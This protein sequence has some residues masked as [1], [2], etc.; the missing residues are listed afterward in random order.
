MQLLV[1]ETGIE[2]Q[3][4]KTKAIARGIQETNAR[5]FLLGALANGPVWAAV[6]QELGAP[7]AVS[8]K[9]NCGTPS[10]K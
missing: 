6:I 2:Q 1:P 8:T 10:S 9:N 5:T 7:R 4:R 3:R